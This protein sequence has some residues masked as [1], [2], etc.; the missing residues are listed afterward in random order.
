MSIPASKEVVIIGAGPIGIEVAA[1]LAANSVDY[2]HVEAGQIGETIFRY[3]PNTL[4]FSSPEWLAIC[5]IPIQTESQQRIVGE[6]YLAYLRQVTEILRLDVLL[7]HNVV[8]ARAIEPKDADGNR[9]E[10]LIANRSGQFRCRCRYLILAT[11]GN[12]IERRIGIEGED[13]HYVSHKFGDPH[14]YFRQK[15]LIVGGRNSALEAAI[16]AWRVGA[17]VA[18]SYRAP[19]LPDHGILARNKLEI[20]L[21]MRHNK[22]AFLPNTEVER[23]A[24]GVAFLRDTKRQRTITRRV[25]FVFLATGYHPDWSIYRSLGVSL[26]GDDRC[27]L[28]NPQTMECSPPGLYVAGTATAGDQ[29][30]YRVFITTCHRHASNIAAAISGRAYEQA[31][32]I[33]QRDYPLSGD[34]VE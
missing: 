13:L 28:F 21:L 22:I 6:Q 18:V 19:Q 27:P 32:N 14:R 11:G 17:Y 9:F 4:F 25:D 34:D 24:D 33:R 10:L 26:V 31:G 29:S 23:I 30:R 8:D 3:P 1:A 16:R 2:L 15:L 20:E 5:G 12:V 7:Y